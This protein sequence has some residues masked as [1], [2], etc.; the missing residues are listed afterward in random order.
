MAFDILA[1]GELLI[2]FTPESA[3]GAEKTLYSQNPGGAPANVLAAAAALGAPSAA[4]SSTRWSATA[5]T[6]ATFPKIRRY[7]PRWPSSAWTRAATAPSPS[8]GIRGQT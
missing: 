6:P 8:T 3:P 5:S 2:D 7:T 1:L 4:S